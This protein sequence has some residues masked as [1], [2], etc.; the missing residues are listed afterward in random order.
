MLFVDVAKVT[1]DNDVTQL[2]INCGI[3]HIIGIHHN[4]YHEVQGST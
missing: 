2:F 3:S 4:D 1:A